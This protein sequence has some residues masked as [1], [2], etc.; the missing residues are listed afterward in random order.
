MPSASLVEPAEKRLRIDSLLNGCPI[1]MSEEPSM[2]QLQLQA[3]DV[4]L[5]LDSRGLSKN[6]IA[7]K[8][9]D[10]TIEDCRRDK[11]PSSLIELLAGFRERIQAHDRQKLQNIPVQQIQAPDQQN[12][13]V[14]QQIIPVLQQNIPVQQIQAPPDQQNIPVLQ[15]QNAPP[16]C[17]PHNSVAK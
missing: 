8:I 17:P 15:N 13:P 11:D 12:I 3:Y 6:D 7:A 14:L 2:I 1:T 10:R 4:L 16:Q 5:E 9:V